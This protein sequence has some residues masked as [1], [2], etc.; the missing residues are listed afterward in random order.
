MGLV[1][2]GSNP[3][4]S[5]QKC[6]HRLWNPPNRGSSPDIERPGRDVNSPPLSCARIKNEWSYTSFLLVCHYYVDEENS[7]FFPLLIHTCKRFL[8]I[9]LR[10]R[11]LQCLSGWHTHIDF[12]DWGLFISV[13]RL[14]WCELARRESSGPWHHL[15]VDAVCSGSTFLS[16]HC[17]SLWSYTVSES[18][19]LAPY[20]YIIP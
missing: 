15:F 20:T 16:Q 3:C 14:S 1:V 17:V 12:T 9:L 6:R 8:V 5:C 19:I 18:R 2:R 4:S 10:V 13:F 11:A 7:P